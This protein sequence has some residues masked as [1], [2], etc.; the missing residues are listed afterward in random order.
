MAFIHRTA[1]LEERGIV[2]KAN[3]RKS[4]R[5]D[6]AHSTSPFMTGMSAPLDPEVFKMMVE[7]YQ[8]A[9]SMRMPTTN[10]EETKIHLSGSG[11]TIA[12]TDNGM[13]R[14]MLA[15]TQ[16]CRELGVKNPQGYT[17]R[18]MH[19]P[20]ILGVRER[21]GELIRDGGNGELAIH[22]S[23]FEAAASAKFYASSE[24]VGFDLDDV[25]ARAMALSKAI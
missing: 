25:V 11:Q 23:V 12:F 4:T 13:N 14:G 15:V 8:A 6:G 18:L 2:G 16:Q 1:A 3:K 17:A 10:P 24:R 7:V 20:E 21:L 5:G 9:A 22:D 19:M